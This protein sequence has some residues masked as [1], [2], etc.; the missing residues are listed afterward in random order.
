MIKIISILSASLLVSTVALSA[1]RKVLITKTCESFLNSVQETKVVASDTIEKQDTERVGSSNPLKIS[2]VKINLS[3]LYDPTNNNPIISYPTLIMTS[4]QK[5]LQL[6]NIGSPVKSK[7]PNFRAHDI[8]I[9]PAFSGQ[10]GLP[11]TGMIVGQ[12]HAVEA[13]VSHITSAARGDRGGKIF[14]AIGP[15]GTGKT[16]LFNVLDGIRTE[17]SKS[18]PQF[19]EFSFKWKGL[20][21]VPA[22]RGLTPKMGGDV[23][24]AEID[25]DIKRSPFTLLRSDMQKEIVDAVRSEVEKRLGFKVEVWFQPAPK[26]IEI[27][28]QIMSHEYSEIASGYKSIDD[29]TPEE[30]LAALEKYVRVVPKLR[31][32][33]GSS[34]IIR[35][36]GGNPN[37]QKLYVEQNPLRMMLYPGQSALAW[38]FTGKVV[39][40]DGGALIFD[41]APRNEKEVLD[42]LLEVAQNS[43]AEADGPP[44]RLDIISMFTGND[45]S[46]ASAR[47]NGNLKAFMDRSHTVPMRL[48]LHPWE[49]AKT[50]LLMV[51]PDKF[52]MRKLGTGKVE[53]LVPLVLNEVFPLP[54]SEGN[55]KGIH[56]RYAIYYSHNSNEAPVLIS[57][58]SLEMLSLTAS[59]TRLVVDPKEF[60]KFPGEFE[61]ITPQH[62]YFVNPVARLKM[63]LGQDNVNLAVRTEL[64]KLSRLTREGESGISSRDMQSWIKEAFDMAIKQG[65]GVLTPEIIDAAFNKL[66]NEET[67]IVPS[68]AL[69][70]EWLKRYSLIK[71]HFTLPGLHRDLQEIIAGHGQRAERLYDTVIGE[72]IALSEDASANSWQPDNSAPAQ[73][74]N[75]KRLDSIK[76]KYKDL[77]NRE[78]S[79]NFLLRHMA[80]S[81]R[82]IRNPELLAA[83]EA[84]LTETELEIADT[85]KELIAYH[86]GSNT[87]PEIQ[88]TASLIEAR[89][90]NYG[91]DNASFAAALSYWSVLHGQQKKPTE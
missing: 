2:D 36:L 46:I 64:A 42:S 85:A 77:H 88:K 21:N 1:P 61:K 53:K 65:F 81:S 47:E 83:V 59:I 67:I 66:L 30:Y 51:G 73:P 27:I 69:R 33:G 35:A 57:P 29:L 7:D 15:A 72:I 62:Q 6:V 49:I 40:Q 41:E 89:L 45:E 20:H 58:H 82:E 17:L 11:K 8:Y 25:P 32:K 9:Y 80:S 14:G 63:I 68:T 87:N 18:N 50:A 54:D 34:E 23:G 38:D 90:A 74:I 48:N 43:V 76:A 12:Y 37:F 16:E 28:E 70:T 60:T 56:R 10:L 19:F 39:Q 44:I 3:D 84:Y 13:L 24:F 5:Y 78:F 91:Y 31:A 86:N 22:L 4:A 75:K 26:D 55:L 52:L 71:N 79:P